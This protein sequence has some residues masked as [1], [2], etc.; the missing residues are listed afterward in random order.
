MQILFMLGPHSRVRELRISGMQLI[1]GGIALIGLL[2]LLNWM[3]AGLTY[4][5]RDTL[6]AMERQ[7]FLEKR[8]VASSESDYESKLIELQARLDDAQRN[9]N[10][11]DDLRSQLLRSNGKWTAGAID[12]N[13]QTYFGNAQGGP[14]HPS[15]VTIQ[16]GNQGEQYGARLDRTVQD[17][18]ALSARVSALQTSLTQSWESSTAILSASPLPLQSAPSSGLGYRSDPF[19]GQ[20]AWHEG[21]DYPAAYGTPIMAT[22]PG[23]VVRAGWDA[24]YGNIVEIKHPNAIITRYAH[25]QEL[26]VKVGDTVKQTQVIAKVGSTGR[27]TGPHLHYEV[28]RENQVVVRR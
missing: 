19:T 22:A 17:S 11:L 13:S 7:A 28:V 24:E 27:S 2:A 21:T 18:L 9:L 10:Q 6:F 25:A 4:Q 3:A 23:M 8:F 15:S 16:L 26:L 14:I 1:L 5:T 12:L 20:L